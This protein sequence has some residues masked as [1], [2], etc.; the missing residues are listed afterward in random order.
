MNEGGAGNL[1][2]VRSI[3]FM[4]S[5]DCNEYQGI[6]TFTSLFAIIHYDIMISDSRLERREDS[7]QTFF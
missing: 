2:K 1:F 7:L 3:I 6:V 5:L 4:Q